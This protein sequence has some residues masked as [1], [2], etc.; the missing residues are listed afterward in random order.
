MLTAGI[1]QT[2]RYF[3]RTLYVF[4]KNNI[5]CSLLIVALALVSFGGGVAQC[6]VGHSGHFGSE[7]TR[8]TTVSIQTAGALACD[9]AITVS[10]CVVF[11]HRKTC[12]RS[13]NSVLHTLT[14]Y[15]IGRGILTS[16][17]AAQ[18][19]ICVFALPDTYYFI[20][21]TLLSEKLYMNSMLFSLNSR[22]HV[23]NQGDNEF[24]TVSLT[25]ASSSTRTQEPVQNDISKLESC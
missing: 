10:L 23:R 2:Y 15:A 6:V 20:V 7:A 25:F 13:T 1:S 3:A 8:L 16:I 18:S 21:G 19:F 5:F 11:R 24:N 9:I 17:A 22:Q 4:E 14:M 12:M